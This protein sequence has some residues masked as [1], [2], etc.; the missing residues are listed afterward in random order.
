MKKQC[1]CTI[2]CFMR[3]EATVYIVNNDKDYIDKRIQDLNE[4]ELE[5]LNK[6]DS[7]FKK[8]NHEYI[9]RVTLPCSSCG[10]RLEV[11]DE[12]E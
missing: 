9:G 1:K 8:I 11:F 10:F 3:P 2:C 4:H 12:Q 5:D 6:E 7:A